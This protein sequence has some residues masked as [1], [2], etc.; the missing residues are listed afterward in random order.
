MQF[1]HKKN[2]FTVDNDEMH[3]YVFLELAIIGSSL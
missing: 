3:S 1:F 2:I